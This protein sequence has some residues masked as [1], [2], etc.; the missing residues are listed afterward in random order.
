[1][2]ADLVAE[3]QRQAARIRCRWV[4][5]G[6]LAVL[7]RCIGPSDDAWWLSIG[8]T[9]LVGRPSDECAARAM[10]AWTAVLAGALT[11]DEARW[12]VR[13]HDAA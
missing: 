5:R 3:L 1:M 10:S 12:L 6:E 4:F 11:L 7:Q 2:R 13:T 9:S 8:A